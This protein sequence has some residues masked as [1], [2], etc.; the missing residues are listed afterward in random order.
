M[1]NTVT[2]CGEYLRFSNTAV[3]HFLQQSNF[4]EDE[5]GAIA[6]QDA[7]EAWQFIN[8]F[9]YLDKDVLLMMHYVLMRNLWRDIAGK[10]RTE[11][12][13][14][15]GRAGANWASVSP[16]I[17]DLLGIVPSTEE[18]IKEWHI[19]YEKIHPFRDGNGRTGRIIMNWQRQMFGWSLLTI[20]EGVEQYEYYKW[21]QDDA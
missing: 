8:Y 2:F 9:P 11:A 13:Y 7:Q 4:I 1:N 6:L 3:T 18:A 14:I 15:G 5:R 12:I 17:D 20:H 16:L 21:F 10:F 19:K